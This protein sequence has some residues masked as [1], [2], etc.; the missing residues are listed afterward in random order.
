MLIVLGEEYYKN[1]VKEILCRLWGKMIYC[2]LLMFI[3][4]KI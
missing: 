3:Y 1:K 4:N 2:S